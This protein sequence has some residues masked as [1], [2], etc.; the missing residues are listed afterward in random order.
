MDL[1]IKFDF[2]I[3]MFAQ[4]NDLI[5]IVDTYFVRWHG[6]SP[7]QACLVHKQRYMLR[8]AQSLIKSQD[9][10]IGEQNCYSK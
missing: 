2:G 1:L 7:K 10:I 4:I 5:S 9:S 3:S 6:H 8:S